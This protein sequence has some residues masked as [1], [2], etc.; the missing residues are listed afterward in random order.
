MCSP[1]LG[2][3]GTER[4]PPSIHDESHRIGRCGCDIRGDDECGLCEAESSEFKVQSSILELLSFLLADNHS[5]SATS[6]VS[7]RGGNRRMACMHMHVDPT[8]QNPIVMI[9]TKEQ[10]AACKLGSQT[11]NTSK[12]EE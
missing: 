7:P 11:Q 8:K 4:T 12:I 5:L 10:A 2:V 6:A 1:L 3:K 9:L